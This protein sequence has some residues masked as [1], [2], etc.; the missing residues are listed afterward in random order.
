MP[1]ISAQQDGSLGQIRRG[2][3]VGSI[4]EGLEALEDGQ[5]GRKPVRSRFGFHVLRL[6]RRMP[7]RTL[8]FEHV[9]D[10][11]ADTLEARSWSV[12]SARYVAGLAANGKVEGVLIDQ[13]SS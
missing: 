13:A 11:I 1:R 4:Q 7:G 2:E 10:K 3:L 8:P 5:T 9:R 12:E 6:H